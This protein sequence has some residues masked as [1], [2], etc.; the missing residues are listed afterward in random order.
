[1]TRCGF[2]AN[3]RSL[4]PEL[5]TLGATP[6]TDNKNDRSSQPYRPPIRN[7]N[8]YVS[9]IEFKRKIV[10]SPPADETAKEPREAPG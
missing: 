6:M 4:V 1:M 2:S 7:A 9:F 3:G 5:R 8:H 10:T